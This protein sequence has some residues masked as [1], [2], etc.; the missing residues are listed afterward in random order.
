M[1]AVKMFAEGVTQKIKDYL[2]EKYQNVDC[3]VTEQQKN[4]GKIL[5]GI[6]LEM[7]EQ[8]I[9]PV[10]YME[11][12]YD[13]VRKGEP[14]DQVMGHIADVCKQA[15]SVQELPENLDF[16]N[17]DSVKDYLAVQ[18][19]NTKANQRMLYQV[20][21]K[22][23]ED[24]SIICRIEFP[25]PDG[26]GIGSVKVTHD[27]IK[28]WNIC[29]EEVYEKAVE[30]TIKRQPPV[31]MS[32]E[33]IAVEM[34]GLSAQTRNLLQLEEGEEFPKDMMYVLSNAR[35]LNGSTVL[36]YPSLQKKL[37]AVF[38]Q[39]CYLL[40]SSLHEMIIIPKDL[41]MEPKEMGAMVREINQ[42]EVAREEV[43]SDRVYEFDKESRQLRQ[44]PDS[45]EKGKEMER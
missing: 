29:P 25:S 37:E 21:H 31:L 41:G 22:E 16:T 45:I 13:Q 1:I 18:I 4:N 36:A 35:R 11:S 17:Y 12:F 38:P 40:P 10:V 7:P 14:M 39:G 43:L 5:T 19:I 3:K 26:E 44:V 6:L 27:L 2:P 15:L 33:E 20:P 9:A 23:M 8:K 28:E 34:M 42:Q 30:N 32:M 24:L